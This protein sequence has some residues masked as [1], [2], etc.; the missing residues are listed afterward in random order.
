MEGIPKTTDRIELRASM[1]FALSSIQALA[2]N[3]TVSQFRF[4]DTEFQRSSQKLSWNSLQGSYVKDNSS[5]KASII[6][7]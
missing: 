2:A 6:Y 7:N 3:M 1:H 5:E 4:Q